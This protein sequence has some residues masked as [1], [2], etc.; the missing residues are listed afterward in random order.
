MHMSLGKTYNL[1]NTQTPPQGSIPGG[2]PTSSQ[3]GG[4]GP[5]RYKMILNTIPSDGIF[6]R[7]N[8]TGN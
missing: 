3:G 1:E 2:P 6:I 4:G 5:L 8:G 7:W